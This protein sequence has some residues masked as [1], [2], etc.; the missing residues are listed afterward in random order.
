MS[1]MHPMNWVLSLFLFMTLLFFFMVGVYYIL[2]PQ[3][4][5]GLDSSEEYFSKHI[6]SNSINFVKN[7][8]SFINF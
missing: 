6:G 3:I 2:F 7:S 8:M 5:S 1:Q 4:S